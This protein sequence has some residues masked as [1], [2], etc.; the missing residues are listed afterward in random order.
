VLPLDRIPIWENWR[1]RRFLSRVE[2][3]VEAYFGAVRY[4]AFPLRVVEDAEAR[5]LREEIEPLL[6]RCRSTIRAARGVSLVRLAP[7]ER[8]GDVEQVD[9]VSV[10]FDLPR[11]NLRAEDLLG[12]LRMALRRYGQDRGRAWFRVFN[13]LYWLGIGL[14]LL[15]VLPFLPLRWL[16]IRPDAAAR[17]LPGRL[18]RMLVRVGAVAVLVA[19]ALHILGY[20]D[21]ALDLWRRLVARLAAATDP[22]SG[23]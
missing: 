7:G 19:L 15:G 3:L 1:R 6:P 11:Y 17:S 12:V 16:G 20:G 5:R 10:L 8:P 9:L 22:G 4:E 21:R 13:P 18:V 2:S 14:D 23:A